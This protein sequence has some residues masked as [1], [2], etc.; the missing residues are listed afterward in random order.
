MKADSGGPTS[1][2]KSSN[3]GLKRIPNAL[4]RVCQVQSTQGKGHLML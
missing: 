1:E 4:N 2:V 3:S